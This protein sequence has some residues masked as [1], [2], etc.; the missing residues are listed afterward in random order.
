MHVFMWEGGLLGWHD[1][2]VADW[3]TKYLHNDKRN[4]PLSYGQSF[5][6]VKLNLFTLWKFT[7]EIHC[8]FSL[9]VWISRYCKRLFL[10]SC[11]GLVLSPV[12]TPT[13]ILQVTSSQG[14]SYRMPWSGLTGSTRTPT[15]NRATQMHKRCT[16][17][18]LIKKITLILFYKGIV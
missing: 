6:R 10:C 12:E 9:C 2:I 4:F 8:I 5:E 11:V 7:T 16:Y 14:R 3:P 1:C 17:V 13:P 15:D 18:T